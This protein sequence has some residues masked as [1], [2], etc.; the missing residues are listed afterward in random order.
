MR[1]ST[2]LSAALI[3]VPAAAFA[4]GINGITAIEVAEKGG[5][6]E[7]AIG[8]SKPPSFTTFSLVDPPRF[9]IDV[10]EAGLDGARRKVSGAGQ[11]R[12]VNAIS[13]GEGTHATARITVTFLGAVEP[14]DVAVSGNR[15]V[16]R[17]LPPAGTMVAA[18]QAA[19]PPAPPPAPAPAVATAPPAA[20][21]APPP[22]VAA[23]AKAS[24]EARAAREAQA[25]AEARAAADV[26]AAAEARAVAD[27]KA[28]AEVRAAAEARAAADARAAAEARAAADARAAAEARALAEVKAAAEVRAA[29]EARAAADAR[30]A[31][32]ARVAA[33]AK[34]AAARAAA[35]ASAPKPAPAQAPAAMKPAPV[36]KTAPV[37][38]ARPAAAERNEVEF[39]GF[40]QTATGSRVFIRLRSAPKFSVSEPQEKLIRVEL[41]NTRVPLRND[42]K[43]LDTSFFPTAVA[44]VTPV[45]QGKSYVLEIRLRERVAWQQRIEGT[46]LSL[47][48]DR[49]AAPPTPPAPVRAANPAKPGK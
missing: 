21:P 49:P 34:E 11:V 23:E 37:A 43:T 4:S 32:E 7:V 27:A 10:S 41:P 45:R 42:L 31:A 24:A 2:L 36:A 33:D 17:V 15:I 30:A 8:A 28:A 40:K 12:E 47:D 18:A 29:A 26:S 13:F 9:V 19:P 14:P 20:P 6:A 25:A 5:V 3:L 16:L 22:A 48:F 44:K 35:V 38:A 46:T 1:K 39:L